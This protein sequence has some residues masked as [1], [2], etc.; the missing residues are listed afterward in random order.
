MS[1]ELH[2]VVLPLAACLVLGAGLWL[3]ISILSGC[4]GRRG[5]DWRE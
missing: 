4:K 1:D 3:F 2:P 5:R